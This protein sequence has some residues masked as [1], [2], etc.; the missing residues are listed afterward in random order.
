MFIR[1]V[2]FVVLL[3]AA[4]MAMSSASMAQFDGFYFG[5]GFGRFKATETFTDPVTAS[6]MTLGAEDYQGGWNVNAGFAG[7]AG[8]LHLAVEAS[9]MNQAGEVSVQSFGTTFRDG[10]E[11]V[12]AVSI[13]P[14]IKFGPD[15]LAYVRIGA[16]QGKL[17]GQDGS[18]SQKHNG[19][20]YGI[21][22]K[23]AVGRNGAV[24]VEFQNYD[25]NEKDGL[26]PAANG[27]LLGLQF[28][29]VSNSS[30]SF[31][32]G[33][34][35]DAGFYIGGSMTSMEADGDC[36]PGFTCDFKDTGFKVFAGVRLNSYF[37]I[38]GFYGNW[39]EIKVDLPPATAKVEAST[40][41][42]AV[43]GIVPLGEHFELFGKVGIG[44]TE[45]KATGSGAGGT[46]TTSER[47]SDVLY[48]A[49]AAFNITRNFGVR[50]EYERLNDSEVNIF[51]VGLQYR[52]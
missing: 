2:W 1:K 29:T 28:S 37:A 36:P 18:F 47:G 10:L 8:P 46:A 16:V 20:V 35:A 49:G 25:F 52:F 21:G 11:D 38:E 33:K 24:F 34:G 44:S 39:G 6:S 3:A 27:V 14:G 42:G 7:S 32:G 19:M 15:G 45:L 23:Q 9:Y 26:Q 50:A 51:S 43:V 41:G 5:G 13:L 12:A 22:M 31:A 4:G 30:A 40:F 17:V 48:G